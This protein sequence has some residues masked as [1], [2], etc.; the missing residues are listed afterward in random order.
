MLEGNALTI[1]ATVQPLPFTEDDPLYRDLEI[2]MQRLGHLVAFREKF[3]WEERVERFELGDE[4]DLRKLK[5][6]AAKNDGVPL[7]WAR[8]TKN[9]V[10]RHLLF[11]PNN[12]GFYLPVR[13]DDPFTITAGGKNV[14]FGS[15]VR[16]GEEL[17]WLEMSM[18]HNNDESLI[19][20]WRAFRELC[21]CSVERMCPIQLEH[22]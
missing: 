4:N 22:T 19:E 15:S 7:F 6:C 3:Q 13:F 14:W 18:N 16:L 5:K 11:H 1:A 8:L 10:Y 9:T 21:Q 17:K 2:M 12:E 20:C